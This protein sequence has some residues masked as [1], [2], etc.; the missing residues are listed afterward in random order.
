MGI[1]TSTGTLTAGQSRTFNLAPA[2]AVTLTLLPNA[3]VTIT[4]SPAAVTA[5]GLGGNAT[6]VH[7]PRLPGSFTYG[8]YPMGG[9]VVVEN[10][11]N[12]GSSV[13]W[14]RSD[15]LIAESVDGTSSLVDGAGN[16]WPG[17]G[18]VAGHKRYP[19]GLLAK[20]PNQSIYIGTETASSFGDFGRGL[21]EYTYSNGEF[22][23]RKI[24]DAKVGLPVSG[25][26]A[27]TDGAILGAWAL[28]SGAVLFAFRSS[29]G[30]Y[31]NKVFLF[32]TNIARD[33]YGSGSTPTDK[34][35]VLNIGEKAGT[36]PEQLR[37]LHARSLCEATIGGANVLF[38]A[39]YSTATGRVS[40]STNDW[41][42]LL[43]ST[44]DGVTWSVVLDWN[45]G[46]THY[47]DHLHF[48]V[49]NPYTG[50]IYIGSGDDTAAGNDE[51]FVLEWD[52][53]SAA[54]AANTD[55]A[56]FGATAGWNFIGKTELARFGDLLFQPSYCYGIPDCD[57]Q[58]ADTTSD[59]FVGVMIDPKLRWLSSVSAVERVDN[60][61][62]I[63]GA[64]DAAGNSIWVSFIQSSA[65]DKSLYVWLSK[66]HLKGE[67][68][69]LVGRIK[70]YTSSAMPFG[71][72]YDAA[73]GGF[74]LSGVNA[75]GFA[76]NSA[77]KS[78]AEGQNITASTIVFRIIDT[79]TAGGVYIDGDTLGQ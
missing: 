33:N 38:F 7:E 49:Q 67:S 63:I 36:H 9:A 70:N 10:E 19:F 3:R 48:V 21:V 71:L 30:G 50:Y 34:R 64:K 5:T 24:A 25:G 18:G 56:L 44:D 59:A 68:W 2:S 65:S 41:V 17:V 52:G 29:S 69:T 43:K 72:W 11:S 62:P 78:I 77:A 66:S 4:E 47:T 35:A 27:L 23:K 60:N 20:I 22:T 40:G 13:S 15:A 58:A 42:R 14:V 26:S 28:R 75:G 73:L 54:P 55:P 57:T 8:P 12:S 61:P 16:V 39:E 46:G 74:V 37:I 51:R 1:S 31:A 32:R 79:V 76:V 6:R 53:V 45:T